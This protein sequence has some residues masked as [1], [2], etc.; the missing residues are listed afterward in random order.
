MTP[1]DNRYAVES[2]SFNVE[3]MDGYDGYAVTITED[4]YAADPVLVPLHL[5]QPYDRFVAKMESEMDDWDGLPA[6]EQQY[7]M[8]KYDYYKGLRD[9]LKGE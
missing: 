5:V 3:Y 8:D 9:A 7:C 6:E 4:G 1:V 2:R